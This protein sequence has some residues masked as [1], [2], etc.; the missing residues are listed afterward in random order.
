M[1]ALNARNTEKVY[2][3]KLPGGGFVAIEVSPTR[4]LF[5]TRRFHG[6]LIL[7]RRA[8][9]ERRNGHAPPMIA[10]TQCTSVAGVFHELFLLAQSNVALANASMK[11]ASATASGSVLAFVL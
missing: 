10:E 11:C 8:D 4:T 7:E 3:R 9:I 5:G 6:R 2:I 1:L